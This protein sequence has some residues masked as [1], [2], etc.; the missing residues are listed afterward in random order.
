MLIRLSALVFLSYL[1]AASAAPILLEAE[2]LP[3]GPVM[4]DP[5]CTG[6]SYVSGGT[7]SWSPVFRAAT[8]R[9]L[10]GKVKLWVHRR[11]GSVQLKTQVGDVQTAH[12]WDYGDESAFTWREMGE[13]EASQLGDSLLLIRGEGG[14]AVDIDAVAL[15]AESVLE[16]EALLPP[17]PV[18]PLTVD[19]QKPGRLVT[20]AHFG[21]N[22]FSA[23]DPVTTQNPKYLA[24]LR[25]MNPGLFRIHNSGMLDDGAKSP[26]GWIDA[27]HK[28]WM[29]PRILAALAPLRDLPTKIVL[30]INTWPA[31]M[32]A[33]GDGRLDLDQH[34]AYAELCADLVKLVN[35]P[36]AGKPIL[37]WEITN[38][39]DDRYHRSF[40]E[41]KKADLLPELVAIY[42]KCAQA[43]R[44]ADPRIKTGAPSSTN[45]YNMD[46]HQRFIAATAAN[47]DFYS[48]HLY[49]TGQ[50]DTPDKEIF[51]RAEAPA[52]PLSS[53]RTMLNEA[54]PKRKIEL[55]LNE[56]NINWDWSQQDARMTDWRSAVWDA[57]FCFACLNAGAD[58]TA[59]W[60]ECDGAYGKTASDHLRRPAAESFHALNAILPGRQLPANLAAPKT[61][62]LQVL[63]IQ[64]K[65]GTRALLLLNIGP[66]TRSLSG[67]TG[68]ATLI[69][70]AGT[71]TTTATGTLALPSISLAIVR[72]K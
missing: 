22:G 12:G 66:R 57:A 29:A 70:Q 63:A 18:V 45:S 4:P 35:A 7:Q 48:M 42:L 28:K 65:N 52:Y 46:F 37:W 26:S 8:P 47:L 40:F 44:T 59:A 62:G 32:D 56:Y 10:T 31:W 21:L 2:A 34:L 43:M 14:A 23:L 49:L 11:G 60:N 16:L 51:A 24:N 15:G 55:W 33:D 67:V 58:A 53:V 25:Y 30:N 50:R 27:T 69:S 1:T 41:A 36:S 13:F 61:D 20:R 9:D 64:R 72:Q 54:S 39:M 5:G 6:G 19:S 68:T 38:E 17:L 71:T 3:Q